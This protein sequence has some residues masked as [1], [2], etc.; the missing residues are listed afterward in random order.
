MRYQSRIVLVLLAVALA[1]CGKAGHSK[2]DSA[3]LSN[4]EI[5]GRIRDRLNSNPATAK[6]NLFVDTDATRKQAM[7]S[8]T[9]GSDQTRQEAISIASGAVPGVK[10]IDQINVTAPKELARATANPK[11]PRQGKNSRSR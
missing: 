6:A 11:P 3:E 7:I 8:G 4:L 5:E 9:A 2:N 10:V 1:G